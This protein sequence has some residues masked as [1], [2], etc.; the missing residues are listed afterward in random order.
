MRARVAGCAPAEAAVGQADAAVQA[1][2]VFL[3]ARSVRVPRAALV[4]VQA[5]PARQARALPVHRVTADTVLRVA[6]A[7]RLA[8]DA[9]EAVGAEALVAAVPGEA[10]L[11]QTPAIGREAAGSG[12]A[13]ARLG[14]V[15]PEAAHRAFLAAPVP[16]VTRSTAALPTEGVT[17]AAIVAVTFLGAVA[18]METLWAGQG[19][20]G[21][22]PARWAAAGALLSLV[23]A[24]IVAGRGLG[25]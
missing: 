10:V 12:R 19:A 1:E 17:E 8:V 18:A 25:A 20:D 7:G 21:T 11:A 5:R 13:V 6:G 14:A 24:L 15:L 9:V 2:T 23:D 22:H 16:G 4:A 3:T